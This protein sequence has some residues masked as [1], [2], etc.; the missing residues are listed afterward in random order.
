MLL[1]LPYLLIIDWS[2]RPVID[3]LCPDIDRLEAEKYVV[4]RG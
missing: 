4:A 3:E 1:T 2:H